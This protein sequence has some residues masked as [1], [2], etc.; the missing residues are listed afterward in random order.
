MSLLKGHCLTEG[1][2]NASA[3]VRN[4]IHQS[5]VAHLGNK[6]YSMSRLFQKL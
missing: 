5:A 2:A 4:Y 6:L 1:S 3:K